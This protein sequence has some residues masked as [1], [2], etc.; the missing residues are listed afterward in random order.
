MRVSGHV[1]LCFDAN[2]HW[3]HVTPWVAYDA[4]ASQ[5]MPPDVAEAF[6]QALEEVRGML[7][8]LQQLPGSQPHVGCAQTPMEA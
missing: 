1:L 7:K 5:S 3:T 6:G 8:K 2:I 4:Q